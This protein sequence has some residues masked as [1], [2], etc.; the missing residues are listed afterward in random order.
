MLI[1]EE[2]VRTMRAYIEDEVVDR[3]VRNIIPD[4]GCTENKD[5][6]FHRTLELYW[7][8]KAMVV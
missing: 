8:V 4:L 1:M 7:H 2:D 5:I 6:T 3:Q